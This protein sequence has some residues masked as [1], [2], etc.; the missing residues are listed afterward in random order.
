MKKSMKVHKLFEEIV[1]NSPETSDG[2]IKIAEKQER[3]KEGEHGFEE[4]LITYLY[5]EL[6]LLNKNM[7]HLKI[8]IYNYFGRQKEEKNIFFEGVGSLDSYDPEK[9]ESIITEYAKSINSDVNRS[10]NVW[11]DVKIP[12]SVN[13][14]REK[15]LD[16]IIAAYKIS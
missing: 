9:I 3:L 6:Y 4:V 11:I 8:S 16:D 14:N 7:L 5:S 15:N 1:S 10:K 13:A 12:N 2:F